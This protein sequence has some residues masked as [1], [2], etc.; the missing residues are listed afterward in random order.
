[1]HR[2][3]TFMKMSKKKLCGSTVGAAFA[4]WRRFIAQTTHAAMHAVTWSGHRREQEQKGPRGREGARKR[5]RERETDLFT[6]IAQRQS[7]CD[8]FTKCSLRCCVCAQSDGEKKTQARLLLT[9]GIQEHDTH[10]MGEKRHQ[11]AAA[12]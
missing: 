11:S 2:S 9:E 10:A 5:E 4:P 8:R 3:W 6:A 7:G 1:M 12:R